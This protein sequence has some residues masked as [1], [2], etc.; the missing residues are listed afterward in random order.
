[1]TVLVEE[2]EVEGV[3]VMMKSSEGR[4]QSKWLLLW[5]RTWILAEEVYESPGKEKQWV[6]S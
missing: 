6:P 4:R 1:M 2:V 5:L 3:L